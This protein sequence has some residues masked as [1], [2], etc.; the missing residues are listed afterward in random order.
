MAELNLTIPY[1]ADNSPVVRFE[2]INWPTRIV[3]Q[4]DEPSKFTLCE[5][6]MGTLTVSELGADERPVLGQALFSDKTIHFPHYRIASALQLDDELRLDTIVAIANGDPFE[7]PVF[8][9]RSQEFPVRGR[10][11]LPEDMT[12]AEP[13][14]KSLAGNLNALRANRLEA[15]RDD[16][17]KGE[18]GSEP[19]V[20]EGKYLAQAAIA[21]D[22]AARIEDLMSEMMPQVNDIT[23]ERLIEAFSMATPRSLYKGGYDILTSTPHTSLCPL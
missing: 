6:V 9:S 15:V 17:E 21:G 18:D 5:T 20:E 7:T 4:R 16:Y 3:R 14:F 11:D 22:I 13:R 2:P 10:R 1:S 23:S 8:M 19:Q 12:V